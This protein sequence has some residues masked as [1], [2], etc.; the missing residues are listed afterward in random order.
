M[1]ANRL[2]L[3]V[4][5]GLGLALVTLWGMGGGPVPIVLADGQTKYVT[6]GGDDTKGCTNDSTD[7][8]A[9]IFRAL[10][11][12]SDSQANPDTILVAT[13]TY[14]EHDIVVTKSVIIQ[15]AGASSTIVQAS[16]NGAINGRRVFNIGATRMW[17]PSPT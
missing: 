1:K 15:G 6:P 4:I 13:G 3:A 11:V 10:Q 7:A 9:T 8:C 17:L 14:T 12:A 16:I 5:A 2:L